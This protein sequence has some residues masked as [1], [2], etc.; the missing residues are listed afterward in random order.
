MAHLEH[1][2]WNSS[3]GSAGI[4]QIQPT[5]ERGFASE[6]PGNRLIVSAPQRGARRTLSIASRPAL[7]ASFAKGDW[8]EGSAHRASLHRRLYALARFAGHANNSSKRTWRVLQ[9]AN[10]SSIRTSTPASQAD[11]IHQHL[12]VRGIFDLVAKP[13]G[14]VV[15]KMRKNNN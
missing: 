2:A 9:H 13:Y 11:Y 12:P 8:S 14:A 1:K 15:H 10:N 3:H 4:V 7:R 5:K 6:I